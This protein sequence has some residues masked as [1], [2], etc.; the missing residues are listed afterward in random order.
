M[1]KTEKDPKEKKLE[2]AEMNKEELSITGEIVNM[3]VAKY[4]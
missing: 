3:Q 4:K 2:Y 1:T